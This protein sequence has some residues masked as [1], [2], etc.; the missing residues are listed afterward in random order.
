[1]RVKNPAAARSHH[2][3]QDDEAGGLAAEP[4]QFKEMMWVVTQCVVKA[5][6]AAPYTVFRLDEAE[7]F[8]NL[9]YQM[10]R[11]CPSIASSPEAVLRAILGAAA[12]H[13]RVVGTYGPAVA[14][15]GGAA[16]AAAAAAAAGAAEAAA[17][18]VAA[19]VVA[20]SRGRGSSSPSALGDR[21][22]ASGGG[23]SSS[24][25]TSSMGDG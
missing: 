19:G 15:A 9:L 11:D 18:G 16:A 13:D 24:S 10:R 8:D 1:M 2:H 7:L 23:D 25:S 22:A 17:A 6:H 21:R 5:E 3:H 12:A 20:G 14:A 4:R